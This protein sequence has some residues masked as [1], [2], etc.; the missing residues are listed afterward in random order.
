MAVDN[1]DSRE[2]RRRT[3]GAGVERRDRLDDLNP[4]DPSD[5]LARIPLSSAEDAQGRDRRGG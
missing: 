2:L 1:P 5:V 3:L 4:A